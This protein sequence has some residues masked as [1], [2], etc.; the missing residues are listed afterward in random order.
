V[1]S[2]SDAPDAIIAQLTRDNA[3]RGWKAPPPTPAYGGGFRP[4]AS[5]PSSGP[6]TRATLCSE[7]QVLY[8]SAARRRG[9][10]TEV[11]LRLATPAGGYSVCNPPQGSQMSQGGRLPLPTLFNPPDAS[12][13]RTAGECSL[14]SSSTGSGTVLRTSMS[15]DALLE[16]YARQLSD[17]GWIAV[18]DRP[19]LVGRT[20]TRTDTA[21]TPMELTVSVATAPRDATCR[22][23]NLQLRSRAR[24]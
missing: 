20:W 13:G 22:D 15:S 24:P 4:A 18:G 12:E 1:L 16:H 23:L 7:Q 11:I 17:S 9:M 19:S 3:S 2:A 21:G 8:A 10:Y 6:Q 5:A 14:T